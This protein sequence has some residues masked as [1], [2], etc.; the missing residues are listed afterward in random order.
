MFLLEGANTKVL[1][2]PWITTGNKSRSGL[3]NYPK[4]K[5]KRED[6]PKLK[7]DYIYITHTHA[8]HFDPDTLDVF[9][10]NIPILVSWYKNNFTEKV[11]KKLGFS[12]VRVAE[13]N[14]FI[15]L[16]AKDKCWIEPSAKYSAVDS[17]AVFQI[18]GLN[19]FNA[20][21]CG[22]DHHQ[23]T[24]LKKKFKNIDAACIPAG[25]QGPY[26][27]FYHNLT[28]EEKKIQSDKKKINNFRTVYNYLSVLKPKY[29]MALTGG[30][31]YGGKKALLMQYTGVGT[32]KEVCSYL[33]DKQFNVQTILLS[34][35]CSYDF[36]ENKVQGKFIDHNYE[37][38]KSYFKEISKMKSPFDKGGIFY[39]DQ[40]EQMDL[41]ALLFNARK[42][43]LEWQ[44]RLN[45]DSDSVFFIDIGQDYIYRM[46]LADNSVEKINENQI[47]DDA[48]EIFRMPYSLLI[49]FLTR[50]YNYSNL[51]TQF[52]D[53]YRKPDEFNPDLH[54]LMSH[55]HL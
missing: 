18:D 38:S 25:M 41:S 54:I 16:N 23:C 5:T 42:K 35:K 28:L 44:D 4:L 1:C 43:Q 17:L 48:Y 52:I 37:N 7:P 32:A 34:E 51:K 31:V 12:D 33:E 39:I 10:R 30:A 49:G 40:T 26:P 11:V 50:H 45:I 6:L 15:A 2:D 8:D 36:N 53:F 55:L 3:F 46:C 9:D 20:N 24:S 22:F 27:A 21:D 29:F 14:K 19:I 13:K 47:I